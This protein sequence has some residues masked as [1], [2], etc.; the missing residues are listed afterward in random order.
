MVFAAT[1]TS[2][3]SVIPQR[4]HCGLIAN[5]RLIGNDTAVV[6]AS[7]HGLAPYQFST[8]LKAQQVSSEHSLAS[9]LAQE[10]HK[11]RRDDSMQANS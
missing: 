3:F 10:I 9:I 4:N 1:V 7:I 5:F 6:L 8:V 2:N 11:L